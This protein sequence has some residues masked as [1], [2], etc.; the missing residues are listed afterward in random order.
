MA[1]SK[2]P[3]SVTVV[4][5]VLL[6]WVVVAAFCATT[7]RYH[8]QADNKSATIADGHNNAISYASL[9]EFSSGNR[10]KLQD[11][12]YGNVQGGGG[13]SFSGTY[14]SAVD[15]ESGSM[16]GATA[17]QTGSGTLTGGG[18]GT[19][20][21]P[22]G[23]I[24]AGGG[25]GGNIDGNGVIYGFNGG[26]GITSGGK[27]VEG[28]G[29]GS[30]FFSLKNAPVASADTATVAA[31]DTDNK[32]GNKKN[33]PEASAT[34][35]TDTAPV[36]STD[37][38]TGSTGGGGESISSAQTT[39][40]TNLTATGA[41]A[42]AAGN[43]TSDNSAYGVG[44]GQGT[45]PLGS[46]GAIVYSD[47]TGQSG[48]AG[49]AGEAPIMGVAQGM[50][51]ASGFNGTGGG[52]SSA[53]AGGYIGNDPQEADQNIP[54]TGSSNIPSFISNNNIRGSNVFSGNRDRTRGSR[55][56]SP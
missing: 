33:A 47:A 46:A 2:S 43:S 19:I 35:Y 41:G 40:T 3:Q 16:T 4:K 38:Y 11:D 7:V 28:Y 31:T 48:G 25:G 12:T 55:T 13:G 22:N 54:N 29:A 36:N 32:K 21:G 14:I 49:T 17:T 27:Q 23:Y 6:S 20:R 1:K 18:F 56:P 45:I 26:E 10:R 30:A 15:S 53:Y 44:Y 24:T 8:Q 52:D 50:G 51:G 42:Y 5:K 9:K 39:G 37:M 34:I